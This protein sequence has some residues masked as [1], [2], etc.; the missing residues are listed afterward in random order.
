VKEPERSQVVKVRTLQA[1]TRVRRFR[2]LRPSALARRVIPAAVRTC[3]ARDAYG[4]P[5][6]AVETGRKRPPLFSGLR[7]GAGPARP[8]G[9]PAAPPTARP[10]PAG[11][12]ADLRCYRWR[13][14]PKRSRR[15][16]RNTY[17]KFR[18]ILVHSGTMVLKWC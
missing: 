17:T 14:P 16:P 11:R 2:A 7:R 15:A 12:A 5:A 8:S 18:E 6:A 3:Q 10:R 1:D 13:R 4:R 9:R